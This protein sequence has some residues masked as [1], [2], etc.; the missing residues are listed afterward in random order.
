MEIVQVSL[1]NKK[2]VRQFLRFPYTIYK[3]TPEWVPP[4]LMDELARFNLRKYPFYAH[5]QAA[6]I[7]AMKDNRPSGRIAVINN[8]LFNDFNKETTAFFYLF[9]CENNLETA[10]LL[11]KAAIDWAKEQGLNKLIGPKGFTPLDGFGLLVKGFQHR[12]ALGIPYN[13]SY[14]VDLIEGLGFEGAGDSVS[15]YL[16]AAMDFPNRIHELSERIQQRRGLSV[17]RFNKRSDLKVLIPELKDLYNNALQGTSGGT[18]L[19]DSE[20]S[21]LASQIMWFA[22]PALIKIVIHTNSQNK[23]INKMVGFLLAYPDISGALQRTGGRLFP[24]GWVTILRDLK[25]TEWINING[26]GLIEEYR[27]LGGTAL[28]FSEM[29]KS[30]V[31]SGQFRHAEIVQIGSDNY[32][33]QRE[34]ENFGINF[35]KIHRVYQLHLD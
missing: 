6:F 32:K 30:I 2:L 3:N 10:S 7:L 33:M 31:E 8:R 26:A 35:N 23:D 4:L 16:D 15:G 34:M 12:P 25:K 20:A 17:S 9:E 5:S 27:G 19:T 24:F 22:D 29:Q 14:Y 21:S 18:P 11:F 1:S 13:P 28:L